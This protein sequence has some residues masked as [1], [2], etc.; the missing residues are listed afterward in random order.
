LAIGDIIAVTD[1]GSS[2]VK[3]LISQI[4]KCNE[5]EI[6][7]MSKVDTEAIKKGTIVDVGLLSNNIK[8]CILECEEMAQIKIKSTYVNIKGFQ[9]FLK[10]TKLE[11]KVLDEEEGISHA[12]EKELLK[13]AQLIN[14]ATLDSQILDIF[15][16]EYIVMGKKY[17][18]CPI[19]LPAKKYHAQ[20]EVIKAKNEI[21]ESISR[22]FNLIGIKVDGMI[23]ECMAMTNLLSSVEEKYKG[24][25]CIDVGAQTTEISVFYLGALVYYNTIPIG[26]YNITN[27][28]AILLDITQKEA[29][30]VKKMYSVAKKSEI[31]NDQSVKIKEA[32]GQ[33]IFTQISEIVGVIEGRCV[34]IFEVVKSILSQ[35]NLKN[36][37]KSILITG[38]RNK[39]IHRN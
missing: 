1:I 6:L 5:I 17:K 13:Q 12:D 16:T 9:V 34:E 38:N 33:E 7:A 11:L 28:I 37:I 4:N 3:T 20:I 14:S 10:N 18:E 35:K 31:I 30:N 23:P 29:E 8:E 26:G 2:S 15:S 39:F 36:Y 27:D 19:G 32:D 22:A 25:L 21:I 24:F